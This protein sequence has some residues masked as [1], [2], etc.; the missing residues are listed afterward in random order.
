MNWDV[1]ML[2]INFR[3]LNQIGLTE[4]TCMQSCD[5]LAAVLPNMRECTMEI[6]CESFSESCCG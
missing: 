4:Y 5:Y 1:Y 3:S 6:L 2:V